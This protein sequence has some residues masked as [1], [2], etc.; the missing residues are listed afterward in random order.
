MDILIEQLH[1]QEYDCMICCE[2]VKSTARIWS[3]QSCFHIYHLHCIKKWA[4]SSS[5]KNEGMQLYTHPINNA[6]S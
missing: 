2:V 4:T 3:C 6:S 1:K 5:A